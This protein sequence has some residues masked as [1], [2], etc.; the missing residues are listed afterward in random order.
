MIR[1][2]QKG[3]FKDTF[4]FLERAKKFSL[5]DLQKY[6]EE[7]VIALSLAT[8]TD[9]GE[10]AGSWYYEILDTPQGIRIQWLN[11]NVVDHVN[12]AVILQYG[13]ATKDGGY[14][15]GRDYINPAMREVF[16]K[17]ADNAWKEVTGR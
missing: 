17:I 14:I 3:T 8:P 10:T 2:K 13:H 6:G 5:K 11:R 15:E 9:T 16:D 7:G 12:I 4:L 1:F